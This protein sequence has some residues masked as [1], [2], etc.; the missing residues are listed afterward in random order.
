[1]QSIIRGEWV[2]KQTVKNKVHQI[3]F[4]RNEKKPEKKKVVDYLY[5]DEDEEHIFLQFRNKKGD[6]IENE[7]HQKNNSL[8]TKLV[9]IYDEIENES[10]KSNRHQ[11]VNLHYFCNVNTEE[12][13][14]KFWDEI[15]GYMDSSYDLGK[16]KK[17][18]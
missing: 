16:V 1:M 12:D 5:I 2:S 6:L 7:N 13:N 10:P 15:F 17:Y 8:I 4:P 3:E 11:M 14:L 18:I 9:Y